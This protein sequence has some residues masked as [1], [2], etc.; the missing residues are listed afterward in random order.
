MANAGSS[1]TA[2]AMALPIRPSGAMRLIRI[3]WSAVRMQ[4]FHGERRS[5]AQSRGAPCRSMRC[6]QLLEQHVAFEVAKRCTVPA[7]RDLLAI[8]ALQ[9]RVHLLVASDL[10]GRSGNAVAD[11]DQVQIRLILARVV[12]AQNVVG[13]DPALGL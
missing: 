6:D 13:F 4:P 3:G 1:A 8:V 11:R 7:A 10:L 2:L 12:V 5:A 9:I